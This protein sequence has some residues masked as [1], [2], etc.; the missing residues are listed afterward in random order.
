MIS[1]KKD[2][3]KTDIMEKLLEKQNE[4]KM[5]R[6]IVSIIA[7]T[8]VL[9]AGLVFGGGYFYI[10]SALK[11][12]DPDSEKEKMVEIPIGSNA[13]SISQILEDSGVI[14]DAR[15]FK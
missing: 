4:A 8:F 5:V 2:K 14:K 7:I 12:L 11:P 13:S 10:K 9:I 1:E 6:K 15:V 3:N